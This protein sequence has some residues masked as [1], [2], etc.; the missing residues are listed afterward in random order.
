MI[1]AVQQSGLADLILAK[2]LNLHRGCLCEGVQCRV[3]W[4]LGR[5]ALGCF[6]SEI[7]NRA[8]H[9]VVCNLTLQFVDF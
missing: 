3:W 7:N 6:G 8:L 5:W 9:R 2:Y 1:M 4:H